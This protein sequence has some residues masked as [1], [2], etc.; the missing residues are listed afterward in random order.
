MSLGVITH[1]QAFVYLTFPEFSW[2]GQ[3][4]ERESL[5]I[6]ESVIFNPSE[7]ILKPIISI[8]VNIDSPLHCYTSLIISS[9]MVATTIV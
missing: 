4:L 9:L 1:A 7:A 5:G 2:L 6:I 8:S 3:V